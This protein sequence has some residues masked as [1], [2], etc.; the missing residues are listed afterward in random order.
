MMDDYWFLVRILFLFQLS[1][2]RRSVDVTMPVTA[3]MTPGS[4]VLAWYP[5]LDPIVN[6]VLASAIYVPQQNLLQYQVRIKV[7]CTSSSYRLSC[8]VCPLVSA[9]RNRLTASLKRI[10]IDSLA[11]AQKR[12]TPLYD[13]FFMIYLANSQKIKFISMQISK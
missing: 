6:T 4:I 12:A 1:P 7:S 8:T 3:A 5:R 10:C 9:L 2:P 13:T 11:L